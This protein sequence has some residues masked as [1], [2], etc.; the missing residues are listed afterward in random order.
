MR[1][2]RYW[3][4]LK[5]DLRNRVVIA[6]LRLGVINPLGKCPKCGK[7]LRYR[8]HQSPRQDSGGKTVIH[9]RGV[10]ECGHCGYI[11]N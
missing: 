9:V 10:V 2:E 11:G 1:L 6:L 5:K 3:W 7:R 4:R 8:A